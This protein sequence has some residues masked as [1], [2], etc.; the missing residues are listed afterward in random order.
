LSYRGRR[1][2]GKTRIRYSKLRVK[3]KP[4]PAALAGSRSL[5]GVQLL[6][7]FQQLLFALLMVIIGY[8]AIH[9][10]DLNTTRGLMSPHAL[11]ALIGV[12]YIDFLSLGDSLIRTLRLTCSA[13][14]TLLGNLQCH[15]F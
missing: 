2:K 13:A 11:G 9:R 4:K 6:P 7:F 8:A 5:A 14:N 3:I 10:A 12:N 1:R 15:F